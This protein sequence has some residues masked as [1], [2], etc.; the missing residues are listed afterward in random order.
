MGTT[1]VPTFLLWSIQSLPTSHTLVPAIFLFLG[2]H[3]QTAWD[4]G[5][6]VYRSGGV[7]G[8]E[9]R[10]KVQEWEDRGALER[11][12]GMEAVWGTAMGAA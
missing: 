9:G 10:V 6:T 3:F 7:G 4:E 8:K 5:A 1:P 11:G 2:T 12:E